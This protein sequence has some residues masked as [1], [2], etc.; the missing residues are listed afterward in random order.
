MALITSQQRPVSA[1]VHS[2]SR[3]LARSENR[4]FAPLLMFAVLALIPAFLVVVPSSEWGGAIVY[5]IV[6]S[7]GMVLLYQLSVKRVEPT[8]PAS[9]FALAFVVKIIGS[10]GRYWMVFGLYDGAADSILYHEHGQILAQYFKVFDFS[11]MDRYVVRGEGT[12]SLAHITG[13]LYS[14]LPANIAGAFFFF[15]AL[16]FTG[17]ILCYC[18]ARVAWPEADLRYYRLCVLFLPSIL[19]W[20]AALGKDAWIL[21]WSGLVA[22]GWVAFIRKGRLSGLL[23]IAVALWLLQLVRP[24]I[25]AF[26]SLSIVIAYILHSTT[27]ER[28]LITWLASG[29]VIVLIGFYMVQS[30]AAFLGLDDLSPESLEAAMSEVQENTTQGGSRYKVVSIFTPT[31]FVIGL[32]TAAMRPF[33]WEA[34]SGQM[35][36][37]ALETIGWL[38]LCWH[39]RRAFWH[40]LRSIRTD[41][42]VGFALIYALITLLA[43]TSIGNFGIIAR[44]RVMALPF[45]WMLFV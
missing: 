1:S 38:Y 40:K 14:V 29:I 27:R 43:L 35:M 31:G 2:T 15:S 20:P 28:S 25:A 45:L 36:L 33:P 17:A 13:L 9:L 18:A 19:F 39:Q 23:W 7:I 34:R 44:Q 6:L 12:T 41:P 5:L 4:H 26:L 42:V 3:S 8:F 16:A 11:I 30:G 24:H 37:S 10:I 32:V 21:C 22:W